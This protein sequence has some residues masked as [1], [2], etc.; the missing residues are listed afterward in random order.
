M[1]KKSDLI[2]FHRIYLIQG[3]FLVTQA[4]AKLMVSQRVTNGSI[5]N[6]ASI[7]GKVCFI[8]KPV[9]FCALIK[10]TNKY[11]R[12]QDNNHGHLHLYSHFHVERQVHQVTF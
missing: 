3:T 8:T 10:V 2:I 1:S 12:F 5:I 7:S 11:Q 9:I 4:V 6:L